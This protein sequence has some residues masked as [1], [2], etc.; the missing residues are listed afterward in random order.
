MQNKTIASKFTSI[1]VLA[2]LLLCSSY[3][4]S[5]AE[6]LFTSYTTAENGIYS[7]SR[8]PL[9][10]NYP[11]SWK[12]DICDNGNKWQMSTV[13]SKYYMNNGA[14]E[15]QGTS[16]LSNS[17]AIYGFT[18]GTFV[19]AKDAFGMP[20]CIVGAKT[21]FI[22]DSASA[23]NESAEIHGWGTNPGK[24]KFYRWKP[25]VE[26]TVRKCNWNVTVPAYI[27]NFNPTIEIVQCHTP[28]SRALRGLGEF[29]KYALSFAIANGANIADL[30][31]K[32]NNNTLTFADFVNFTDN[33]IDWAKL[34]KL[35][36][37]A[38]AEAASNIVDAIDAMQ[39]EGV[40]VLQPKNHMALVNLAYAIQ[41]AVSEKNSGLDSTKQIMESLEALLQDQ[42]AF[43]PTS[44]IHIE[45]IIVNLRVLAADKLT[46]QQ[47]AS[48]DKVIAVIRAINAL[49]QEPVYKHMDIV[50]NAITT[51][52]D[53]SQGTQTPS[54]VKAK[55]DPLL[56]K[57]A[58]AIKAEY[59]VNSIAMAHFT[60][61]REIA[62]NVFVIVSNGQIGWT[63]ENLTTLI[64]GFTVLAASI[65]NKELSIDTL[66]K[67]NEG[68]MQVIA[69]NGGWSFQNSE[70]I[71][72]I[73]DGLQTFVQHPLLTQLKEQI[74]KL[75]N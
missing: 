18:G 66:I 68:I 17:N 29:L 49:P 39:K 28:S 54:T 14:L 21:N 23:N 70:A 61:F 48:F 38:Q 59:G 52:I 60:A 64:N 25:Y 6:T 62:E 42:S 47:K 65:N 8:A 30:V 34:Q 10:C 63:S 40:I 2:A 75:N 27:M 9:G 24:I 15:I 46:I 43:V 1:A 37:P 3:S 44:M 7:Y 45:T 19:I 58:L 26:P 32:A 72:G 50:F 69:N 56:D 55:L 67:F 57:I 11:E 13:V 5:S 35:I 74:I 22:V 53:L 71:V 16:V 51:T 20:I 31:N 12:R 41:T 36:T 33:S 4:V 73:I